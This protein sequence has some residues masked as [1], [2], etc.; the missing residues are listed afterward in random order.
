MTTKF[1]LTKTILIDP[2]GQTKSIDK[3]NIDS[4]LKF[5]VEQ[6]EGY[7]NVYAVEESDEPINDEATRIAGILLY[8]EVAIEV[9]KPCDD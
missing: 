6:L 5:S 1:K 3:I 7:L 9:F 4:D 2:D 8:G